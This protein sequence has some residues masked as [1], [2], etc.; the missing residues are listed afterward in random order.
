MN[1]LHHLL[2]AENMRQKLLWPT[3]V[4]GPALLGAIAPDAHS[5]VPGVGRAG[6]HPRPNSDVVA[7]VFDRIDTSM[8]NNSTHG[9]AFAASVVSHLV[10]DQLTRRHDYHLPAHAPTGFQPVEDEGFESPHVIEIADFTRA[11]RLWLRSRR[12]ECNRH[13][14]LGG[15]GTLATERN[16]RTISDRRTPRDTGPSLHR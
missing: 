9:R 15:A 16:P 14:A 12:S 2:V 1:L 4:R 3:S 5:E 8:C 11:L 7:E 13:Q 10:A 6:V